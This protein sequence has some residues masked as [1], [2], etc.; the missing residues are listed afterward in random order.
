MAEHFEPFEVDVMGV[1]LRKTRI[2]I[3][4]PS[5]PELEMPGPTHY[6]VD[7]AAVVASPEQWELWKAAVGE[8]LR[9]L[10]PRADPPFVRGWQAAQA[11]VERALTDAQGQLR[12]DLPTH[13]AADIEQALVEGLL[14][15]GWRPSDG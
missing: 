6:E 5:N 1:H 13:V 8:R 9:M 10:T 12:T 7:L 14:N 2:P 3:P 4:T 15:E 11:A